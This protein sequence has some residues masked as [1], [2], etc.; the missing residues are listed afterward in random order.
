MQFRVASKVVGTYPYTFDFD[1]FDFDT[2]DF[3]TFDFD[4]FKSVA[5]KKKI[6]DFLD[7]LGNFKQKKIFSL[8]LKMTLLKVYG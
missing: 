1:T 7:E 3:D 4:T 8:F 2:F 5:F 6:I